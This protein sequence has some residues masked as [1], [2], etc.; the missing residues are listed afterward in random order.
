L[1]PSKVSQGTIDKNEGRM[2]DLIPMRRFGGE[3]FVPGLPRGELLYGCDF[4]C[5]WRM[6]GQVAEDVIEK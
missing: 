4:E 6:G 3:D 2:L 1:V 5:G